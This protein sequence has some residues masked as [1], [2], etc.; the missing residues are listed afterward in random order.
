M[1][2]KAITMVNIQIVD[3]FIVVY[4][5]RAVMPSSSLFLRLTI[6]L[7]NCSFYGSEDNIVN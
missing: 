7:K 5:V 6:Y 2:E 1:N 3:F 4:L